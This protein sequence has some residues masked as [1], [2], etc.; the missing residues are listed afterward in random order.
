[1]GQ[2]GTDGGGG[3]DGVNDNV[4]TY[5]LISLGLS[6]WPGGTLVVGKP[7]RSIT[8]SNNATDIAC[9]IDVLPG[10]QGSD[11]IAS[12]DFGICNLSASMLTNQHRLKNVLG[13]QTITLGINM[14]INV[15]LGNFV[16]QAGTMATQ[17]PLGGCGSSTPKPRIC[18]YN[19]ASPYNLLS[20]ENQY[21]F[22]TFSAA[23][24]AA[25]PGTKNVTN[26]FELANRALGNSDGVDNMENGVSLDEIQQAVANINEGF[27]NC[28][29]FVGWNV[30]PCPPIDPTPG[31]GRIAQ[32]TIAPALEVTAYPNPYQENFSLKVNSPVTGQATVSFYTIDGVKVSEMKRD[33]VA[34]KD[35]W[36]PFNVPAVYRTRIV[37]TVNV[38]SH[39]AKGVVLSPN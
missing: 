30:A 25:I 1:M 22:R 16:L 31:D 17:V 19:V 24:I 3:C 18:H 8:M 29:V 6:R 14:G 26:L 33:V 20:V 7:G 2:Y 10:N 13:G 28:M 38:G 39:N 37:Y 34:K 35:V 23:L 4:S 9:I 15:Q 12:G 21:T 11:E 5:G 27:D 32:T 36:I